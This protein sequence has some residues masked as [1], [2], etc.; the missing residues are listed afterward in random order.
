M[1]CVLSGSES[2]NDKVKLNSDVGSGW[3]LDLW[4]MDLVQTFIVCLVWSAHPSQKDS[5]DGADL[6]EGSTGIPMGH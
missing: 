1:L 4:P 3:I 2:F 6:G 5:I